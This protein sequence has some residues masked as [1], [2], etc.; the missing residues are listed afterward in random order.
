[1][2]SRPGRY[3]RRYSQDDHHILSYSAMGELRIEVWRQIGKEPR[4]ELALCMMFRGRM[5]LIG[6]MPISEE[7]AVYSDKLDEAVDELLE[8]FGRGLL[9]DEP[10]SGLN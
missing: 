7:Q 4:Y 5:F 6:H 1:M 3:Q 10:G 9:G 2:T 8:R